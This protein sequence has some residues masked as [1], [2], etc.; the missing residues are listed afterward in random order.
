MIENHCTITHNNTKLTIHRIVF[1]LSIFPTLCTAQGIL[2]A[3][4]D[5]DTTIYE[6]APSDD[7]RP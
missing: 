3:A 4:V 2:N 5:A 7:C 6:V 1:E